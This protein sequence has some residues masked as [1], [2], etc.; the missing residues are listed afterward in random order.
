M[1]GGIHLEGGKM[2]TRLGQWGTRFE[3]GGKEHQEMR[4]D[5]RMNEYGN[6]EGRSSVEKSE[7]K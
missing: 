2:A 7:E 3:S 1:N 4:G 5:R 6:G